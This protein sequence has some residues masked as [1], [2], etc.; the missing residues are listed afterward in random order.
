M[1]YLRGKTQISRP[2]PP[3]LRRPRLVR[4]VSQQVGGA[5]SGC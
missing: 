4:D 3:G 1:A 2:P 5:R